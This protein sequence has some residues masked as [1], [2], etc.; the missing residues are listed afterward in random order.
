M[1]LNKCTKSDK[2][3]TLRSLSIKYSSKFVGVKNIYLIFLPHYSQCPTIGVKSKVK[4]VFASL[5]AAQ[6]VAIK[7]RF[8]PGLGFYDFGYFKSDG[9]SPTH[10]VILFLKYTNN[11][12]ILI[13]FV[14]LI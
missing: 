14:V 10:Q 9:V 5:K 2:T 6:E 13:S 7:V 12:E 11:F 1:N 4:A 8:Y 3:K